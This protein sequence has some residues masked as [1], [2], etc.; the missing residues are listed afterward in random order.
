MT[1]A[2][3][4]AMR[5]GAEATAGRRRLDPERNSG[6]HEGHGRAPGIHGDHPGDDTFQDL[7]VEQPTHEHQA[8]HEDHGGTGHSREGPVS[9]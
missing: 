1:T 6:Q 5:D 2:P 3:A 8:A 9:R 7:D 4:Q